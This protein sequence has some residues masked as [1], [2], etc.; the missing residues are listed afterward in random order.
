MTATLTPQGTD[1]QTTKKKRKPLMITLISLIVIAPFVFN[2]IIINGFTPTSVRGGD[3][4]SLYAKYG[5]ISIY[6]ATNLTS[7]GIGSL[8]VKS[9]G[10]V[11]LLKEGRD[12]YINKDITDKPIS[13]RTSFLYRHEVAHVDQKELVAKKAGGY[14]TWSNPVRTVKYFYYLYKL[15]SDYQKIMPGLVEGHKGFVPFP[16]LEA[17]ADC[18]AMPMKDGWGQKNGGSTYT[19]STTCS[20]THKKVSISAM[21]GKWPTEELFAQYLKDTEKNML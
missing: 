17:A 7:G 14:P 15:D 8:S 10:Y 9:D 12:I 6:Q 3:P 18:R 20:Y 5:G 21:S 19:D 2:A 1:T 16:G 13:V 11:N 4:T